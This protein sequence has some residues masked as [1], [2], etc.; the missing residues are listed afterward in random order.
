M[1]HGIR[2]WLN[3]IICEKSLSRRH[4][5]HWSDLAAKKASE[6]TNLPCYGEDRWIDVVWFSFG[7]SNLRLH[8]GEEAHVRVTFQNKKLSVSED[9]PTLGWQLLSL[10]NSWPRPRFYI[11][12]EDPTTEFDFIFAFAV[13]RRHRLIHLEQQANIEVNTRH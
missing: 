13:I 12:S 11:T 7:R 9:I 10:L 2:A 5:M 3:D 8:L 6:R 4:W 1:F